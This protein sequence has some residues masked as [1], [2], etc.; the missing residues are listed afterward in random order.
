M[1]VKPATLGLALP[2]R[3]AKVSTLIVDTFKLAYA[4]MTTSPEVDPVSV[5]ENIANSSALSSHINAWLVSSPRSIKIPLSTIADPVAFLL[6]TIIGS[7]T[8]MFTVST[9]VVVPVTLRLPLTVKFPLYVRLAFRL[10][11]VIVPGTI[12]AFVIVASVI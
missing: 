3:F 2:A 1:A 6:R 8:L 12:L 11:P 9:T 7:A 10:P 5:V 4:D